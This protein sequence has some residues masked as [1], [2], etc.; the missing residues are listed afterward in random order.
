[1]TITTYNVKLNCIISAQSMSNWREKQR[2]EIGE[3]NDI[4][5][6]ASKRSHQNLLKLCKTT[7]T[8]PSISQPNSSTKSWSVTHGEPPK[9]HNEKTY[10]VKGLNQHYKLFILKIG[11]GIQKQ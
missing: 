10:L 2:S 6:Q 11:W 1:M 7:S 3:K 4:E 9:A 5:K 8:L